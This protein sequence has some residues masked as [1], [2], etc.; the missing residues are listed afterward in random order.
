MRAWT[1]CVKSC[2][3]LTSFALHMDCAAWKRISEQYVKPTNCTLKLGRKGKTAG[4]VHY[5]KCCRMRNRCWH[6]ICG[7][8]S[9][10]A[11][12]GSWQA[13]LVSNPQLCKTHHHNWHPGWQSQ[14]RASNHGHWNILSLAVVPP[15]W[16]GP[17]HSKGN[18][19]APAWE[20]NTTFPFQGLSVHYLSPGLTFT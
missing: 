17:E 7:V 3:P 8:A 15:P 18:Q 11:Y 20:I 16:K 5:L 4:N 2:S 19:T 13:K 1:V 10:I 6:G 12:A 9:Y 14:P